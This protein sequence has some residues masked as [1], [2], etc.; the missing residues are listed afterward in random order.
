MGPWS[1]SLLGVLLLLVASLGTGLCD[2][3]THFSHC[4]LMGTWVFEVGPSS[5]NRVVNCTVLPQDTHLKT[6]GCLEPDAPHRYSNRLFKNNHNFVKAINAIQKSWTATIYKE[7]ENLTLRDML[8]K[9]GGYI[10]GIPRPKPAPVTADEQRKI[11][12]LPMSW[13]W[14]NVGGVNYVSPIRNQG[15]CGSCYAFSSVSMLEA[16]LRILTNNSQTPILSPQDVVSCN[17]YSKGCKGGIPY[18]TAGKYAQ[19]FG[20]VEETCFPYEA[21]EVPCRVKSSCFRYYSSAYQYVGGYYGGCNEAQMK[22]ELVHH[23]PV[24]ATFQFYQD[25]Y[26][27]KKGIYYHTGLRDPLNPSERRSHAVLIVGYGTDSVSGMDY[28]ICKNSWGINWG[29]NGYFRIRRGTNE[30]G[31]EGIAL[32][33]TPIPKL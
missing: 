18:L 30:C 25:F 14:R 24:E 16:R 31:I 8:M 33:A 22:L 26:N 27:Y 17:P 13:D 32:A 15:T 28:W 20:L 3:S 12:Q 5:S 19:D 10:Q 2:T 29:E 7:Y 9:S 21:R 4:N 6:A 23:G 1:C 11:S